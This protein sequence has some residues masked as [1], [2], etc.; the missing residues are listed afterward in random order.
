M[1]SVFK[2]L[3]FLSAIYVWIGF[4]YSYVT[5]YDENYGHLLSSLFVSTIFSIVS[6]YLLVKRYRQGFRRHIGPILYLLFSSPFTIIAM[7]IIAK[8]VFGFRMAN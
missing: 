6:I 2:F 4:Y 5:E 1:K 8:D 3:H 7:M